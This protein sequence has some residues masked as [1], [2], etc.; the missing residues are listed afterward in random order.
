MPA[1]RAATEDTAMTE[2]DDATRHALCDL[3]LAI[4]DDKL[5][6]GHRN[7]DWTG[8]GPILEED[9]AFSSIAQDEIAHAQALYEFVG[10]LAGTTADA[11]AFG[12]SPDAYRCAAVV[13]RSDDN[14]WAIALA[15]QLFCDHLDQLRL[16]RLSNSSYAPIAALA[17]RLAAEEQVHVE[18]A[19]GWVRRLGSGTDESRQ[20]MQAA[21]DTLAPLS[22]S[23]LE[24]VADQA[25]LEANGVYPPLDPPMTATWCAKLTTLVDDAGLHLACPES[26]PNTPGGRRGVHTPEFPSILDEMCEVYRIEPD[27]A[28]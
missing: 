4:A 17:R 28:W 3:L 20:R 14:D 18:H 7:S 23:L 11:L 10:R 15:R 8:L 6:L 26:A 16:Q 27:A 2:L 5:M 1:A 13:E 25:T 19:D 9:I 21:L 12:R 22:A 24:A